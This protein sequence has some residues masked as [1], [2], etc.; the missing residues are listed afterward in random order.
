MLV[1]EQTRTQLSR[2]DDVAAGVTVNEEGKALVVVDNG[3]VSAVREST[4]GGS[5]V[6]AGVSLSHVMVPTN[7]PAHGRLTAT[8]TTLTL[9]FTPISG[10]L[11]IVRVSDATALTIVPG[12]PAAGEAQWTAGTGVT[13][14]AADTGGVFDYSLRYSATV[15]QAIQA[16]GEG[17]PGAMSGQQIQGKVGMITKG[18]VA[19]TNYSV[20]FP[21][22]AG[23]AVKLGAG[24]TFTGAGGSGTALPSVI[25]KQVP[26]AGSPYLVL[27]LL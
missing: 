1:I 19:T 4:G 2:Q 8:G 3:G 26:S 22:T 9:P 23:A 17:F 7:L 11:R 15:D 6:F 20:A 27:E 13:L 12:A 25:C 24:G 14:N 5:E 21:F 18:R 16:Y 10:Q